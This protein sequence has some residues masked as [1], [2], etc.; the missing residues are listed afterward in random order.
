MDENV[1]I[2]IEAD[3][4]DIHFDTD[5]SYEQD[6]KKIRSQVSAPR[7][8]K[9]RGRTHREMEARNFGHSDVYERLENSG[10][11]RMDTGGFAPKR[12]TYALFFLCIC[13]QMPPATK[14]AQVPNCKKMNIFWSLWALFPQVFFL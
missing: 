3:D 9:G 8:V 14:F 6:D 11:D 13:A 5:T 7:N 2:T 4:S 10:E 12:C 1:N